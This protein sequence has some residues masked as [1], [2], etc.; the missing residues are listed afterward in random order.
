MTVT[1]TAK[2]F[3]MSAGS[4]L[5]INYAQPYVKSLSDYNSAKEAASDTWDPFYSP[6]PAGTSLSVSGTAATI[7]SIDEYT[8][9]V[10]LSSEETS[11]NFDITGFVNPYS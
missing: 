4:C 11:F 3:T 5:K 7:S 9:L 10:T 6:F 8:V 1:G 2:D